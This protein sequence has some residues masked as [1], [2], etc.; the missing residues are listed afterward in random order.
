MM[1]KVKV[2][3]HTKGEGLVIEVPLFIGVFYS[4][5]FDVNG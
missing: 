2:L 1:L 5:S 4:L 3:K